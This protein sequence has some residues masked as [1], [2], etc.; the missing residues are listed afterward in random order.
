MASRRKSSGGIFSKLLWGIVIASLIVAWYRTP[1]QGNPSGF[2]EWGQAKSV[3]VETWIKSWT[4]GGTSLDI[5]KVGSGTTGGG[6]TV[7]PGSSNVPA[8]ESN[9]KL[10]SVAVA[11]AQKVSYNRDEW[12]HWNTVSNCWD[13]RE[14]VLERDAVAGSVK[15]LDKDKKPTASKANAC[16]IQ[17]GQWVDYYSGKTFTDPGKLDI[18]HMIPLSYTAQHGGQAWDAGKKSSYANSMD[19]GHLVA[20]S[21]SENRTKG[22]KGPS[23]WKPT[24]K[25]AWCQYGTDWVSV[26]GKWNISITEADKATLGE[27]LATC[28]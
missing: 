1:V 26:A 2:M 17:S 16:S 24:D 10:A 19:P 7:V 8:T 12:K 15:Y 28:K 11:P 5:P 6:K 13:V 27:L 23:V 20:V 9:A 4:N 21:A 25:G 14:E 18:D 22:D 3:A